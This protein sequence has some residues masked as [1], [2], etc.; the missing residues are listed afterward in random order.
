MKN[1]KILLTGGALAPNSSF[2]RSGYADSS[3]PMICTLRF[4]TSIMVSIIASGC[5]KDSVR[6]RNDSGD[7]KGYLTRRCF[8]ESPRKSAQP[9]PSVLKHRDK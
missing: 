6:E 7:R 4:L 9:R 8:E 3:T 5:F 1:K 2:T